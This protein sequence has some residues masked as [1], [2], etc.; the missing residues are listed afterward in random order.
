MAKLFLIGCSDQ[1][2]INQCEEI[3]SEKNIE[4][5]LISAK[6][7]ALIP[8]SQSEDPPLTNI[9]LINSTRLPEGD[10]K[11]RY[12]KSLNQTE[13]ESIRDALQVTNGNISKT[14]QVLGIGRATVY[15]KI[16]QFN[17]NLS[18]SRQD[19]EKQEQTPLLKVA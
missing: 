1:D 7:S 9:L 5:K 8:D 12:I 2:V 11:I 19:S 6:E 13:A 4:F 16:K 17:I 3:S 15:R 14:S 10:K 18:R